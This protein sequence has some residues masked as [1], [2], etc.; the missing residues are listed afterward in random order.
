MVRVLAAKDNTKAAWDMIKTM[1]IGVDHVREAHRQ[2]I[3]KDFDVM[4]F[5]GETSRIYPYACPPSS[6]SCCHLATPRQKST[7]EK[8]LCVV[9]TR[10]AQMVCSIETLLKLKDLSIDELTDHLAASQGRGDP[11]PNASGQLLLT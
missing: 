9:P 7:A 4:A 3:Q 6:P 1:H 10:H 8:I 2:K 5:R 11:E